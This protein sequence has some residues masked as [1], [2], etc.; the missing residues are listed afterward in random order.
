MTPRARALTLSLTLAVLACGC[1]SFTK[2]AADHE[3][4]NI[5][6]AKRRAVPELVGTLHVEAQD[7]LAE[8]LRRRESFMLDTDRAVELAMIVSRDFRTEREDVYLA[9]L[10]FTLECHRFRPLLGGGAGADIE[11]DE[12]GSLVDGALD[13]TISRAFHTGGSIALTIATDFLKNISAD[14]MRMAQ[15]I[16]SADI[17]VPLLR[18][19]GRLVTLEPLRQAGRDTTYALRGYARFQQELK[20]DIVSRVLRA[21]ALRDTWD[22]EEAAYQSLTLLV[23]EQS[24]KAEAGKIPEFQLDQARQDLL[25]ADDRRQRAERRYLDA[26]D[27]LKLEL[28]LPVELALDL[29]RTALSTLRENELANPPYSLDDALSRAQTKRLDLRNV[30]DQEVDAQRGVRIAKDALRASLDLIGT[31]SFDTPDEKPLSLRD[32]EGG[33][34]LGFDLDLPLE[35]T[36]ERNAYVR[37]VISEKR[38]RRTRQRLED[39]VTFQVR[40]IWRRLEETRRSYAIQVESVRLAER[41]VESTGLLL[42]QG[43]ADIRDRLEAESAR[44]DARNGLTSAIVDYAIALLELERDVGTLSVD[45]PDAAAAAA[46]GFPPAQPPEPSSEEAK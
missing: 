36:A 20:V 33:G 29:D 10:D 22:N 6:D 19:S 45:A 31:G 7:A 11:F 30:R 15:T 17:V 43:S 37:S 2:T 41:R 32:A 34:S 21:L 39:L 16:I 5:L 35:R 42:Q 4:Y 26:L 24:D 44:R 13:F 40:S 1:Q 8:S 9:A 3:V 38:S 12:D 23:N 14:P 18:G 25:R 46:N 27:D 28:G